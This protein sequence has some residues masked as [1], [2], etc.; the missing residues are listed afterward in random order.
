MKKLVIIG[1]G[2]HGSVVADAARKSG[3]KKIVF[4]DDGKVESCLGYPVV[5]KVADA[6]SYKGEDFFVAIGNAK[7][8]EKVIEDLSQKGLRVVNVV[9]PTATIAAGVKMGKGV[10]LVAG[11]IVNPNAT[12]GDGVIVN[13][14]ASVDHDSVVEDY[15]HIAV[16][17]HLAGNV[18][19]GKYTWLGIGAVVSN[20]LSVCEDCLIGAGATVVRDI[21]EKG[22]YIGT[23]AR[24]KD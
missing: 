21:E 22:T 4:L 9:H 10:L 14:H 18:K 19:L 6:E 5:G 23:P 3:Y 16:G 17:A 1:A 7:V 8:R 15:C 20:G 12:L 2:G 24:K 13:T 11:S